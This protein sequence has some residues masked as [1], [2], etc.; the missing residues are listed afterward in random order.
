MQMK[1]STLSNYK[2]WPE[3]KSS[4]IFLKLIFENMVLGLQ[5]NLPLLGEKTRAL[6]VGYVG[7]I[8]EG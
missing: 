4:Q 7:Y 2:G 3:K 6:Y 5:S 1:C 8:S